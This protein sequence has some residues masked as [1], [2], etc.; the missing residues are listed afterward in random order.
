VEKGEQSDENIWRIK[1]SLGPADITTRTCA[2][3]NFF[4]QADAV[5][6]FVPI[7]HAAEDALAKG[8]VTA[9]GRE[10]R[11]SGQT[12]MLP[13]EKIAIVVGPSAYVEAVSSALEAAEKVAAADA[14]A[15]R[16]K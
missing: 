9:A 2:M 16:I 8:Y 3:P 5:G 6:R 11:V 15:R 4:R 12:H 1:A 10:R 7:V 13:P 14:E